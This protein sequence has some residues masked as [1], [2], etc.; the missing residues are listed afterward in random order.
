MSNDIIRTEYFIVDKRYKHI[1]LGS[2][3]DNHKFLEIYDWCEQQQE[4][5]LFTT[6]IVYKTEEALTT[7]LL[8]WT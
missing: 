8:R 1:V 5:E 6:G 2:E 4:Y 7:F 3:Y